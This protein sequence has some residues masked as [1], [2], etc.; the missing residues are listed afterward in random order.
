MKEITM[1]L[2]GLEIKATKFSDEIF[3]TFFNKAIEESDIDNC[4]I[5]YCIDNPKKVN[6]LKRLFNALM[7]PIFN[8]AVEDGVDVI[9]EDYL[10]QFDDDP[11]SNAIGD[12]FDN[13]LDEIAVESGYIA[14]CDRKE[15]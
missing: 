9:D 10:M 12:A 2:E 1:I 14:I 8:K 3:H 11:I 5:S 6:N 13:A 7:E 15:V 4:I